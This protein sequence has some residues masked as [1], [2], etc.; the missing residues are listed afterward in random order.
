MNK[1]RKLILPIVLVIMAIGTEIVGIVIC[2]NMLPSHKNEI[3]SEEKKKI[4][5]LVFVDGEDNTRFYPW[6]SYHEEELVSVQTYIENHLYDQSIEMFRSQ[7]DIDKFLIDD[8]YVKKEIIYTFN[9]MILYTIEKLDNKNYPADEIDFSK[10]AKFD[11]NASIVCIK[12]LEYKNQDN[13]TK[14]L[15]LVIKLN[16]NDIMYL[17]IRNK[18]FP[19]PTTQEIN[20]KSKELSD[21]V[22][23]TFEYI[24][25]L[26]SLQQKTQEI[27]EMY[28]SE[29]DNKEKDNKNNDNVILQYLQSINLTDNYY[30]NGRYIFSSSSD[31]KTA[32]HIRVVIPSILASSKYTVFSNS[33]ELMIV[34]S[35]TD[36]TSKYSDTILYYSISEDR[37]TGFS[38]RSTF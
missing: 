10:Y 33:D 5:Q 14:L 22:G 17:R 32:V 16:S 15:D 7:L 6:L 26:F 34:F 12:D 27:E 37:I 29:S 38:I 8:E 24:T 9:Q 18:S 21:C 35:G 13:E 31:D 23:Q 25:E 20:Q 30:E 3:F 19:K 2:G 11:N 28:Y 36:N 4:T 1:F